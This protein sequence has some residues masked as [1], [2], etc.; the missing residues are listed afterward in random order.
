MISDRCFVS[1]SDIRKVVNKHVHH[2]NRYPGTF[3]CVVQRI[4][5][6]ARAYIEEFYLPKVRGEF[7]SMNRRTERVLR[8]PN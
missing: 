4:Q 7:L 6:S 3:E 8:Q 2:E 5:R 1:T